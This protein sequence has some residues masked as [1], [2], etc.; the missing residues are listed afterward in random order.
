MLKIKS[1]SAKNFMSIGNAS[2]ALSFET[3]NLTLVLGE[4]LDLGGDDAGSRNGT[5]K[6]TIINALSYALF[7]NALSKISKD[8]L[9]NKTNNKHMLVTCEF[10]QGNNK[11]RIERGR[12]PNVLKFFINNDEKSYDDEAQ[13][14]N[15]FTQQHIND[16]LC[17]THDMFKHIVALN[18]Y[19]VPFLSM[20]QKDQRDVIEQLLGITLLSEKAALLKEEIK[21]TNDNI[22]EQVLTIKA[23][24]TANEKILETI[25]GLELKSKAWE[26]AHIEEVEKFIDAITEL[27]KVDIIEEINNQKALKAWTKTKSLQKE[28]SK[29]YDYA[30]KEEK[31]CKIYMQNAEEAYKKALEHKCP[32]CGQDLH[33]K[34]HEDM[35]A[36]LK[37]VAAKTLHIH[38]VAIDMLNQC[39]T[40]VDK[41][42]I[43]GEKPSVFYEDEHDATEHKTTLQH[44]K[45]QLKE[46][47]EGNDPYAEQADE[48]QKEALQ[49][50][51]YD[52]VNLLNEFLN[53]QEFLFN[54]LT[55]KDSFIRRKIIDQNLAYLN[56]RLKSYIGS[57][58]LP[59][60]V[61]F[62]ND[63]SVEISEY[64]RELDFDN[65]SRGERLRLI[66]SLSWAFRDV[67][68]SI[69]DPINLLFIDELI[70][71][72]MDSSGVESCLAI[73]K[74][75]ARERNKGIFLISHNDEL[76]GRVSNVLTVT[77]E[78]GFTS[79]GTDVDVV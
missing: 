52:R 78:N 43:L 31:S 42:E 54:L 49:E 29:D 55:K 38:D 71:A 68:E 33:D 12:K 53:H 61:Q 51:S 7:G 59:H 48:L 13:G 74:K 50:V 40:A 5:G 65:L 26:K 60:T 11:Y 24:T 27:E 16:I 58:G 10:E 28:L 32:T 8:N 9:V 17:L 45:S 30:V 3:T 20:S 19:T 39:S 57:I 64:G 36:N 44:L 41:F 23:A 4:N 2:Q 63:L 66:L 46:K 72:G 37:E 75:M 34:K 56:K 14:E 22:R 18:T 73:L 21:E 70:D 76:M 77:K 62:M 6:T 1:L 69:Y 47:N 25:S 35:I 15:R 79:Y 67:Y